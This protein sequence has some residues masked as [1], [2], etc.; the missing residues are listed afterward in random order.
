MNPIR[1]CIMLMALCVAG[2]YCESKA[3]H[4]A[5]MSGGS[6]RPTD[7]V[8]LIPARDL[9]DQ[10]QIVKPPPFRLAASTIETN[11][12]RPFFAT[13]ALSSGSNLPVF[14]GGTIGRLTRWAGFSSNSLISDSTIFEDKSGMVGIGTD[15]PASRLTVAGQIESTSIG[16]KFPDGSVQSTAGVASGLVVRSLN[17]AMGDL[18]L[19]AGPNI[20][21]TPSGN[22]LTVSA[23]NVL[24]GVAHDSTLAGNGGIGSP[25]GLA[26][27]LALSGSPSFSNPR[28]VL[29]V[30]NTGAGDGINANGGGG[31]LA[32]ANGVVGIGGIGGGTGDGGAGLVGSGGSASGAANQ[33]GDGILTLG[34]DGSGGAAIGLAANLQ[35]DVI[36][37][38]KLMV[39]GT[40]MFHIDHPLD[41]E[42]K[43]LNHAAIESSEVKNLY[44]G[45]VTTDSNGDAT[46]TLPNWF[47]ALNRDFRYQLTVVGAFA[48][49]IVAEK[50]KGNRFAIK[51]SAPNVEVNWQ[52]TGVRRDPV[53]LKHPFKLEEDK[54]D[55]ERGYYLSPD[56][57]GQ[58]EEKGIEWARHPEMMQ[59]IK[60]ARQQAKGQPDQP[61]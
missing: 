30:T 55:R 1:F 56:A 3:Q 10:V 44:D 27:P 43:Y 47:E 53:M 32:G 35:G 4:Q 19:Q 52:V 11:R 13:I 33:G 60:Q 41:P 59:R 49:A 34:G 2:G 61:R 37:G 9:L 20:T 31:G 5:S 23:A 26:T 45:V 22:S 40:K 46:V 28:P 7:R 14:G 6:N 18:T 15:S 51:T 54:S 29:F 58:P 38:G 24:T 42:N 50:I 25:L 8:S 16:I 12:G 36:V 57:Y 39:S 48:Q 17:G 21:I